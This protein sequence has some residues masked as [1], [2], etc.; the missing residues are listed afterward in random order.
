MWVLVLVATYSTNP[1]PVATSTVFASEQE[2]RAVEAQWVGKT[3]KSNDLPAYPTMPPAR[4]M[5][6]S[7]SATCKQL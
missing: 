4:S 5:I 7:L 6:Q 1:L 2:C 3:P